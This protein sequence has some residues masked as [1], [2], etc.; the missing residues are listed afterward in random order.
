MQRFLGSATLAAVFCGLAAAQAPVTVDREDFPGG[1]RL[2]FAYEDGTEPAPGLAAG[3]ENQVLI[4]R[5]ATPISLNE[6]DLRRLVGDFSGLVRI[7]RDNQ[8]LRIALNAPART[9]VSRSREITALDLIAPNAADPADVVSPRIA[10]ALAQEE[11]ARQA[12]QQAAIPDQVDVDLRVFE[13]PG[14]SR[15]SMAWPVVA[16]YRA[17][18]SER[19]ITLRFDRPATADH[20]LARVRASETSRITDLRGGV[21]ASGRY[22][23]SVT[24]TPGSAIS[25]YRDGSIV[26]IDLI[27]PAPV[28]E[29]RSTLEDAVTPAPASPP[30]QQTTPSPTTPVAQSDAAA[31]ESP[32]TV[33]MDLRPPEPDPSQSTLTTTPLQE[34]S[35]VDA[36]PATPPPLAGDPTPPQVGDVS[37]SIDPAPGGA[38]I[39]FAFTR[40]VAAAAF[41]SNGAAYAVFNAEGEIDAG[42][43]AR[44]PNGLSASIGSQREAIVIRFT[45]APAAQSMVSRGDRWVLRLADQAPPPSALLDPQR[46]TDPVDGPRIET[47]LPDASRIIGFSD[48][49]TGRAIRV[50]TAFAPSAG[51]V[52]PR[53]F[54]E[55][56][57]L[58]SAHGLAF[59]ARADGLDMRLDGA[60]AVI[61]GDSLTGLALSAADGANRSGAP[62][63]PAFMDFDRWAMAYGE[64]W[65]SVREA[66]EAEA[67]ATEPERLA[68][69]YLNLARFYAAHTLGPEALGAIA[70][71]LDA[72]PQREN[73]ASVLALRAAA[74][75]MVGR[76]DAAMQD[77]EQT[78][79]AADPAAAMWRAHAAFQKADFAG[80]LADFGF[81][82]PIIDE[83]RAD[84]AKRFSLEA[85][86]AALEESQ[87]ALAEQWLNR[88][89]AQDT[90]QWSARERYIR[91]RLLLA[92]GETE[93]GLEALRQLQFSADEEVSARATLAYVEAGRKG[94]A[95][96][97]EEAIDLLEG[98]RFRWR[99]DALELET[100]A[101]LSGLY[102][103]SG[104]ARDGLRLAES[105]A[106][107]GGD[108]PVARRLRVRLVEDFRELFLNGGADRLDP[109]QA[110]AIYYE[111]SG[112]TPINADGD[113]MIR[114]LARRLVAFDLLEQ[115]SELLQ[116]QV[117]NRMTG[118]GQAQVAADLAGVYLMDRRPED[119]LRAL[120]NSRQPNLPEDIRLERRVLEAAAY[121]DLQ[122]YGLA[123][124]LMES[125]TTPDAQRLR[126]D[127]YWRAQDWSQAANALESLV[128]IGQDLDRPMR[129]TVVRAAIAYVLAEDVDALSALRAKFIGRMASGP[130]SESFLLLTNQSDITGASLA[131]AT[132]RL[133]D[134]ETVNAFH[135][136]LKERFEGP[137]E[138]S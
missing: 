25:H 102:L 112:L 78:E 31:P 15:V 8:T 125:L 58:Q 92:Q 46:G 95:I 75:L 120:A 82:E 67:A 33:A 98:L 109:I 119:A 11:A 29:P 63:S 126:A 99:G 12:A 113:R 106:L 89:S 115:A 50:A 137:T 40:P 84:W 97:A 1:V 90:D 133:A 123:A 3:V 16:D 35:V 105:A 53:R 131:D 110:L 77:L 48:P 111:F 93:T 134:L 83:M 74:Q 96:T 19:G 107:R 36:E 57:M 136:S 91:S 51:L 41:K 86:E 56:E 124:E 7:D 114:R 5:F 54:I 127:I 9:H 13:M 71:A 62:R 23:I 101:K 61:S 87:F 132:R 52:E 121:A 104:R 122:R 118:V 116:Y 43:L 20:G 28:I 38:E 14:R 17:I 39:T 18:P 68:P 135:Q 130:F 79:I 76:T 4:A 6:A 73:D 72:E 66:L 24:G 37:V 88:A 69:A 42:G 65:L 34:P 100:I 32:K 44:L 117:D 108:E 70:V 26:Y 85:A 10:E 27:D 30:A 49:A 94:D 55:G 80:A 129:E 45:G 60:L 103:Q 2:V 21:G 138:A 22:E 64:D 81:A 128:P 47:L 59:A